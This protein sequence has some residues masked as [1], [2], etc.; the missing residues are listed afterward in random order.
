MNRKK[1]GECHQSPRRPVLLAAPD[2][3]LPAEGISPLPQPLRPPV[4][5][6]DRRGLVEQPGPLLLP[7]QAVELRPSRVAGQQERLLAVRD[8]RVLAGGVVGALDLAGPQVELDAPQQSG[9]RVG[10]EVGVDQIRDL[11]RVAVELDQVGALDLAEVGPGAALVDAEQRVEGLQRRAVDVE[12]I[13]QE[14][15]EGRASAGVVD[16]VGVAGPGQPVVGPPAAVR[17][18]AEEGPDVPLESGR[19]GRHRRP[20]AEPAEG[21]VDEQVYRCCAGRS[22]AIPRPRSPFPRMNRSG[23]NGGEG[24]GSGG[25]RRPQPR[26]STMIDEMT[27]ESLRVESDV[28]AGPYLEIALP[29]L[30]AVLA[31]LDRHEVYYWVDADAI[32]LDNEPAVTVINF[33]KRRRRGPDPSHPRRG[34]LTAG[35]R[36]MPLADEI[37]ALADRILARLERGPRIL[38]ALAAG[39]APRASAR[40]QGPSGRDRRPG[41]QAAI[42]LRG[43]RVSGRAIRDR[44][45]RRVGI[46]GSFRA[47]WRTGFSA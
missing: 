25:G 47:S 30:D 8:R 4:P 1:E 23:R 24:L 15:A 7:R 17:I 10:V 18:P 41:H 38:R 43:P 21:Q 19:E 9:V 39:L 44:P 6:A 3:T 34:R 32:S 22:R 20:S 16:R 35:C 13:G 5:G 14:L 26:R 37:R 27:R 31:L 45:A 46:Q 11:A 12:G 33:G 42:A 29:Q 2:R 36:A 28:I 40:P